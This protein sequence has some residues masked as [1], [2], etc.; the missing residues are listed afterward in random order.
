M[1][2]SGELIAVGAD[3]VYVRECA[4]IDVCEIAR[5]DRRTGDRSTV[6]AGFG[7]DAPLADPWPPG[8]GL[9]T[10]VSPDGDVAFVQ[11]PV[12]STDPAGGTAVVE[13]WA[14]VDIAG[15]KLTFIDDFDAGQPVVWSADSSF[16]TVL[17]DSNLYV[18]DRE[19]GDLVPLSTQRFRAIGSAA[20]PFPPGTAD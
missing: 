5:V 4:T 9:G 2:R 19:A 17:A 13:T 1:E 20:S 3:T 6:D 11:L 18:F 16:A 15:R 10:S 8:V 14:F 12:G 7:P